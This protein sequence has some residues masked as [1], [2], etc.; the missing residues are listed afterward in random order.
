MI[1]QSQQQS[2]HLEESALELPWERTS[3]ELGAFFTTFHSDLGFTVGGIN[4]PMISGEDVLGLPATLTVFRADALYRIGKARRHQVD[5]S[6]AGYHR[7]GGAEL[8][9]PIDLGGGIIIPAIRVDSLLNFD[10]IRLGY[11]YAFLRNDHVRVGGGLSAYI[12]PIEYGLSYS[13]GNTPS[14]LQPRSLTVP[15]PALALRADFRV[16]RDLYITSDLNGIYLDIAGFQGTLVDAGVALEYRLWK[17]LAMGVGY[18]GMIVN[19]RSTDS[20]PDYPGATSLGELDVSFH[21]A[22]AFV[23]VIF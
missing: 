12:L 4:T 19:V 20:D 16:W 11:S 22:V 13:T 3:L 2:I 9:D 14:E 6:Y 7:S 5:L 1:A 18:N 15:A 21:G 10:V 8:T 23:K 17:H